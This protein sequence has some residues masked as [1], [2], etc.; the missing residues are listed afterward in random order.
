MH[1]K[2]TYR[3]KEELLAAC[4]EAGVKI[5]LSDDTSV[6]STRV[7]FCGKILPNRLGTAPMEGADSEADGSPSYLTRRR[8]LAL[9]RGGA[10]LIW[11]EAVA[12]CPESRSSASALLINENNLSAFR[13]LTDE[14]RSECVKANGFSPFIVMQANHSGRYSNPGNVPAPLIAYRNPYLEKTRRAEDGDIVS[15]A[16]LEEQEKTE[17]DAAR[18]ARDAGFDAI[19]VK[20]C[21]G[22]LAAEL[23]SAFSRPGRYG[24]SFENRSRFLVNCAKRALEYA[25]GGFSVT[26]RV[27]IYDGF[28]YPYGFGSDPRGGDCPDYTEP[29][30]LLGTLNSIGI[31]SVCVT[32]GNPYVTTHVTR[33]YNHGKYVPDEDPLSG[34]ARMADGTAR[35]KKAFP[36]MTVY[37]SAPSFLRGFSGQYAAGAVKEGYCDGMLFGRMSL[38]DP[39]F[40]GEILKNGSPDPSRVCLACGK[41]GDLIRAHKPTGCVVRDPGTYLEYYREYMK[42]D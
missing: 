22:Y 39:G 14:M 5:P 38:A 28:P 13:R 23:L 16:Y 9:A 8:Y 35:M 31:D 37:A 36:G 18:L 10:A 15:D 41:C 40:A 30:A 34:I 32:M 17:G 21:H 7:R 1:R 25:N 12:V 2:F 29:E 3:T 33:P 27:G 19:D 6:L 20:A 4:A 11:F 26:S 42:N 24:G